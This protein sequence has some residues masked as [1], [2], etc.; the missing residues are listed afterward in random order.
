MLRYFCPVILLGGKS[1][2][3]GSNK[4]AI[5]LNDCSILN[6]K[7]NML[8]SIGF[9]TVYVSG[10]INGYFFIYDIININNPVCGILSL[11]IYFFNEIFSHFFL[12]PIDIIFFIKK[13]IFSFFIL[14]KK[15][16]SCFYFDLIFPML[17]AYSFGILSFLF[18]FFLLK[19]IDLIT[20]RFLF[21]FIIFENIYFKYFKLIYF[22]NLNKQY[23][24]F[25]L[26]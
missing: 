10:V 11:Y 12:I 25:L 24:F 8:F 2:R 16:Y 9:L 3:F 19:K 21:N 5:I 14:N 20:I 22:F 1:S 15:F 6:N 18:R 13:K 23:D 26:C 17:L 4:F 7:I